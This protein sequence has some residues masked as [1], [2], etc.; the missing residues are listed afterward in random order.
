MLERLW[1]MLFLICTGALALYGLHLYVLL[2]LFRRR[3]G[4]HGADQKAFVDR[5]LAQTPPEEWLGVTTQIAI[6][7]EAD[8]AIRVINAVAAMDYPR[9]RHQIQVLDDS[10]DETRLLIDK[11]VRRLREQGNDIEVI[12]R[13]HRAG[14]KAG[15]LKNGLTRARHPLIAI[16]DAD[17][18]PPRDFLKRATPL[19]ARDPK[20]ACLQGRWAHLNAGESWLTRAQSVGID[21]HFAV[22]QGARAWNGLL[23]NFNG[24]AGVWRKAAIEDP[25][26]GGWSAD[27]LTEDLDLSYR[28]QL[29]GWKIDYC[30]DLACPSELPNTIGA[31]K[32]QQRRWATGSIQTAVKLLPRIWRSPIGLGRK[33]EATFH[34]THYSVSLWMLILAVLAR[35]VLFTVDIN[36]HFRT[37]LIG[38]LLVLFSSLAPSVMYTYARW[39]LGGGWTGLRMIP[40]MMVLGTGLSINN[41]IAV[42]RGLYTRGG[43]FVRTP[44]SGST[45]S[46][47]SASRYKAQKHKVMWFV[48][49][50]LGAYCLAIWAIYLFATHHV[51]ISIFLGIYAFGYLTIGW[52]SRPEASLPKRRWVF[53]EDEPTTE[54]L[55]PIL[56]PE[57]ASAGV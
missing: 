52:I 27:T 25:A 53:V 17:F 48:E 50:L 49:M 44:K 3:S 56:P 12:R 26:G 30:I 1:L 35:P 39:S 4:V 5:Y 9:H 31:L 7:N 45:Q 43:E 36:N 21:G 41:A 47:V 51:A 32:A 19:L 34:L 2:A 28:V 6:Y 42:L 20:L 18:V 15:A 55:V 8:V 38:W 11:T 29:A 22:E 57:P 33:L 40:A 24:T 10:T 14:F 54:P 23:M 46:L 16:F 13:E 37:F